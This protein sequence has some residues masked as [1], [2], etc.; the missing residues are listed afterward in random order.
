MG[1][2]IL[3]TF[4][5]SFFLNINRGFSQNNWEYRNHYEITYSASNTLDFKIKPK[6]WFRG[7]INDLYSSDVEIGFDKKINYWM[8]VSPYYRHIIQFKEDNYSVI[9]HP[10]VDIAFFGKLNNISFNNRNRFEYRIK[11][12]NNSIR[13]RNKLTIKSPVYFHDKIRLSVAEEPFYD[14]TGKEFNKNRIY[15]NIVFPME[16]NITVELFYILEHFKKEEKW[17][18]VNV[19]GTSLKY[20]INQ[21][22]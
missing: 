17:Q 20:K 22:N 13:Y 10:Q 14:C 5:F 7:I 4:L 15:F 9:Y 16:N 6:T 2:I 3:W 8:I 21:K 19:L 12:D 18:Y 1:K 11:E